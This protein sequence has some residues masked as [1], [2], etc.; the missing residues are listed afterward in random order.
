MAA[1]YN[2]FKPEAAHM[3]RGV[4][5]DPI[6][7]E[8]SA[9]CRVERGKLDTKSKPSQ[10][11]LNYAMRFERRFVHTLAYA[12][13]LRRGAL[14]M[15]HMM[16]ARL[17]VSFGIESGFRRAFVSLLCAGDKGTLFQGY[18]CANR[19]L[20]GRRAPYG[21]YP[22]TF[23]FD[24]HPLSQKIHQSILCISLAYRYLLE[25]ISSDKPPHISESR[26]GCPYDCRSS[27]YYNARISESSYRQS[28]IYYGDVQ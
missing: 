18:V 10:A 7:S 8:D 20:S 12:L 27:R 3:L 26:I 13:N 5:A 23:F 28:I 14:R 19:A 16:L 21:M 17:D 9:F 22:S 1:Y 11:I 15:I 2:E 6:R 4:T 25:L 24:L